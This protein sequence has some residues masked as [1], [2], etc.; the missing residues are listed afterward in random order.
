MRLALEDLRQQLGERAE[1]VQSDPALWQLA[2]WNPEDETDRA[3]FEEMWA[4]AAAFSQWSSAW[5]R[6]SNLRRG[7]RS[8]SGYF[9]SWPAWSS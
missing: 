1:I 3:L 4:G 2:P 8:S 9:W 5:A 6:R 7:G